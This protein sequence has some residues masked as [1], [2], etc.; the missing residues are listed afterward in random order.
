M[1]SGSWNLL[2]WLALGEFVSIS[3]DL[4]FQVVVSDLRD[5]HWMC[6][7]SPGGTLAQQKHAQIGT[8][9]THCSVSE[10]AA[11][12][13]RL[14]AAW[15]RSNRLFPQRQAMIGPMEHGL[16]WG[17]SSRI[18]S[19]VASRSADAASPQKEVGTPACCCTSALLPPFPFSFPLPCVHHRTSLITHTPANSVA[20]ASFY[21][22]SCFLPFCLCCLPNLP[23]QHPHYV[24]TLVVAH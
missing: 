6:F 1:K 8:G 2:A 10:A 14:G 16:L 17:R 21:A 3:L 5:F 7:R 24:F 15:G 12:S 23:I 13:R 20:S 19:R 4:S 11:A 18:G 22:F 9:A